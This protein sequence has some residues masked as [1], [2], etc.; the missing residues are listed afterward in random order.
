[1]GANSGSTKGE[2]D[3]VGLVRVDTGAGSATFLAAGRRCRHFVLE[4]EPAQRGRLHCRVLLPANG[5][6]I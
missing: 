3:R 2:A 6:H 4:D 1:M 5:D